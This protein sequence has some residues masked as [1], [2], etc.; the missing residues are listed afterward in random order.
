[1]KKI[2][3]KKILGIV[4]AL[5]FMFSASFKQPIMA[6]DESPFVNN[7]S[8]TQSSKM[9]QANL[10]A[11]AME[12]KRNEFLKVVNTL[13]N[14]LSVG[15]DGLLLLKVDPVVEKSLDDNLVKQLKKGLDETNLKIRTGQIRTSQIQLR[16]TLNSKP[17]VKE[18]KGLSYI[19][20]CTGTNGYFFYW[21]GTTFNLDSCN[22]KDMIAYLALG[23]SLGAACAAQSV[24][25]S[26][27]ATI[28]GVS[29]A[30][31]QIVH[32]WGGENGVYFV[33]GAGALFSYV[34]YQ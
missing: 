23:A 32:N 8:I 9:T 16:T 17:K 24:F 31:L 14:Y 33:L 22:T 2:K 5:L 25:C 19:S 1:M 29:G 12:T 21:W 11:Q 28:W 18:P 30:T 3:S 26:V 13:E 27:P 10:D 15:D 34:W 6:S 4:F 7:A 20:A